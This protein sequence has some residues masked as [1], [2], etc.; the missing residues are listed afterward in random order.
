MTGLALLQ[1]KVSVDDSWL[2]Y[3]IIGIYFLF[4]LGIGAILRYSG[5]LP[6]AHH[7]DNH[8][9][10]GPDCGACQLVQHGDTVRDGQLFPDRHAG[11]GADRPAGVVHE[12]DGGE[13][14]RF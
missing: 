10:P 13:H 2:D 3:L 12:R 8:P 14:Y 1:L 6:G 5:E 11:A 7:I 4:V 9:E